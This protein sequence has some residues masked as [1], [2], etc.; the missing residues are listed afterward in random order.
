MA[1]IIEIDNTD[2]PFTAG[3]EDIIAVDASSGTVTVNLPPTASAGTDLTIMNVGTS[4]NVI[5]DP[6]G[7]E[8]IFDGKNLVT[9]VTLK[10]R[11]DA[12]NII[13]TSLGWFLK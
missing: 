3:E 4:G 2:S 10:K 11:G 8:L 13:P 9:T 5:I 7:A 12:P 6:S 1:T